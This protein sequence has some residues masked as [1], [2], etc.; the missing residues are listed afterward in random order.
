MQ[1]AKGCNNSRGVEGV[2]LLHD[3]HG[4][5]ETLVF[6]DVQTSQYRLVTFP[7]EIFVL[8][9]ARPVW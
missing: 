5:G 6:V 8:G 1:L 4:V 9:P 7:V 2:L 3:L